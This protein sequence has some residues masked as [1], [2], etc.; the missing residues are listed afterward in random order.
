[1]WMRSTSA[2]ERQTQHN[3]DA[4]KVTED[5]IIGILHCSTSHVTV[6]RQAYNHLGNKV[7]CD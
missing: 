5:T 4:S 3:R 6:A 2:V 7:I 1:M